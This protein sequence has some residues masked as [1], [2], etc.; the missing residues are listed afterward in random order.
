MNDEQAAYTVRSQAV[1]KVVQIAAAKTDGVI[2]QKIGVS[3]K[4][5]AA[6]L[7]VSVRITARY[8]CHL[9]KLATAVQCHVNQAV[10]AML[11]TTAG[12]ITVTVEN[13]AEGEP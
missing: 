1:Q 2:P 6:D 4:G 11:G 10:T 7:A 5:G 8:G 9:R 3:V 13:V 12:E